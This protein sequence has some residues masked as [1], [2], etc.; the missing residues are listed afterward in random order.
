MQNFKQLQFPFH[1]LSKPSP[2]KYYNFTNIIL[3]KLIHKNQF[4][5]H[6]SQKYFFKQQKQQQYIKLIFNNPTGAISQLFCAIIQ[7]ISKHTPKLVNLTNILLFQKLTIECA[8]FPYSIWIVKKIFIIIPISTVNNSKNVASS[9]VV[10][11]IFQSIFKYV[12]VGFPDI[13]YCA[14]NDQQRTRGKYFEGAVCFLNKSNSKI[15]FHSLVILCYHPSADNLIYKLK[16][17]GDC[18]KY[19]VVG[20]VTNL[21]TDYNLLQR[22][23]NSQLH[24]QSLD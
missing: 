23:L 1:K 15:I 3:N 4:F 6:L 24:Q 11:S 5:V 17:G 12:Y 10:I 9:I 7:A 8:G 19:K 21:V 20:Q 13:V 22:I 18:N 14:T 2:S 16:L